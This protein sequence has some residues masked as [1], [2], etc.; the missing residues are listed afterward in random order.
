MNNSRQ[1]MRYGLIIISMLAAVG[2]APGLHDN[3][4]RS[5]VKEEKFFAGDGVR[6]KS[7][8]DTASFLNGVYPIDSDGFV[9]LPIIGR[10]YI[11][12]KSPL[13]FM[14][15][16]QKQY[17]Q[18]LRFPE[19]IVRPL[20]RVSLLGG[21]FKPGLYYAEPERS[22]WDLVYMA[23]GTTNEDGIKRMRMERSRQ[24]I[25]DNLVP[26]LQSGESIADIGFKS[27]DQIW[28]PADRSQNWWNVAVRDVIVLQLVPISTLFLSIYFA[29]LKH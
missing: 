6:I 14:A 29:F 1:M 13:Q 20:I 19:L 26:Y 12:D 22:I 15:M 21:F 16:L 7:I 23:G 18:Y 11:L 25:S 24:V 10:Y 3:L 4:I 8:Q 9:Y 17:V 28:T 5:Q 2:C 27:G